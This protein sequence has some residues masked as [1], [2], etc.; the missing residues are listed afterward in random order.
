[1]VQILPLVK[2]F[3]ELYHLSV[4][5]QLAKCPAAARLEKT[6]AIRRAD[7][8]TLR[9]LLQDCTKLMIG[10]NGVR[11]F[12]CSFGLGNPEVAARQGEYVHVRWDR[13][14]I[15]VI[16]LYEPSGVWICSAE[17]NG[18]LDANARQEDVA[19]AMKLRKRH[20]K[21]AEEMATAMPILSAVNPAEQIALQKLYAR[22]QLE[23]AGGLPAVEP[24]RIQPIEFAQGAA[25]SGGVRVAG[26]AGRCPG[27]AQPAAEGRGR[28]HGDGGRQAARPRGPRR[29]R[30]RGAAR[31]HP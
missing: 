10:Q 3:F 22:K 1:M 2:E 12:G 20:D 16:Y 11:L 17:N 28:P 23:E 24:V 5:S 8:R 29:S 21:L 15:G 4:H 6:P 31:T 19:D 27:S 14:K 9:L 13:Q 26:A 30:G 18:L 7:S 25:A